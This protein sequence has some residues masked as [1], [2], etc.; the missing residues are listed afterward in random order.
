MS[1]IERAVE[2]HYASGGL[3]DR[4]KQAAKTVGID[5]DALTP[6][7]LAPIDQFHIRGRQA[8]LEM[9]GLSGFSKGM[10]VLDVGCGIGGPARTL[11]AETGCDVHGIDLTEEFIAAA[12]EITKKTGQSPKVKFGSCSALQL[13]FTDARFDGAWMQHVSM[14]IPDKATLLKEIAR[15]VKP[16]GTFAFHEVLADRET[17]PH[18]PVPW[19]N[20]ADSSDLVTETEFKSHL[21]DAGLSVTD[22]IDVTKGSV[23]W[24]EK[25]FAQAGQA[26]KLN[27]SVLMGDRFPEMARNTHRSLKEGR[28]KVVM[29][30]CNHGWL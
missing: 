22:W 10:Y 1:E 5:W 4:L 27:L 19:A 21:A 20:T 18:F 17:T 9:I 24:F 14:N 3:M 25:I 29:A 6:A 30:V 7:D 23:A 11:A 16:G 12:K 2:G 13:P 26:S 15:V 28:I 8:T